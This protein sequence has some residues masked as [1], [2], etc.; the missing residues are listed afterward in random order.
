MILI[1]YTSYYYHDDKYWSVLLSIDHDITS[2]TIILLIQYDIF[3]H[4]FN[5]KMKLKISTGK[6][7][8]VPTYKII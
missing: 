8:K 2:G 5:K 3:F 4:F 1:Q 6:F 7:G